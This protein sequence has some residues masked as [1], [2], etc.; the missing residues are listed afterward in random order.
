MEETAPEISSASTSTPSPPISTPAVTDAPVKSSS[1]EAAYLKIYP[2]ISKYMAICA[3][4]ELKNKKCGHMQGSICHFCFVRPRLQ[5]AL[6]LQRH[7]HQH[8][9][10]QAS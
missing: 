1:I 7:C 5:V 8:R 10:C 6:L 4:L 2:L 3:L 9:H